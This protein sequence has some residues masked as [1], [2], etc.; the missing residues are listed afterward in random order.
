MRDDAPQDAA[1]DV[2]PR[3]AP[4]TGKDEDDASEQA[5]A[6]A[7]AAA[8]DHERGLAPADEPTPKQP[9]A[10]SGKSPRDVQGDAAE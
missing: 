6:K 2:T 4:S 7:R 3:G 8:G 5:K 9:P 10:K 1:R